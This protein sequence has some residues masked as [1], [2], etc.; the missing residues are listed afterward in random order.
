[1]CE[2]LNG[3]YGFIMLDTKL[4]KVFIGRDSYGVRPLYRSF[5]EEKGTLA[6]CSEAKGIIGVDIGSKIQPVLPGTYEEYDLVKAIT[7]NRIKCKFVKSIKYHKIGDFPKYDVDFS[8]TDDVYENIRQTFRNAVSKRIFGERKIGCLLSGGLGSSLVCGILVQELKKC[9]ESYPILTF[10]IGMG[11]DSQDVVAARTVSKYLKTE[12]HEI[13]FC[14]K[15]AIE[16]I[17]E[18]IRITGTYDKCT[19][20]D[21]IVMNLLSKYI[22]NNTDVRCIFSG[23]G[24]DEITQ[25][26]KAFYRAPSSEAANEES[27]RLLNDLHMFDLARADHT[28][29]AN[30]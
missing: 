1:M 29:A 14:E 9:A 22:Q 3:E 4:N 11:V 13:I 21:A 12:H 27:L 2:Q 26:Y 15:E 25:G 7:K 30:G 28:T 10:S 24:N 18:V 5:S 6:V 20:R 19:I 16:S 17:R 8:L 23:D